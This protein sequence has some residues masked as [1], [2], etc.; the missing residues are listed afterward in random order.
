MKNSVTNFAVALQLNIA[1]GVINV[2]FIRRDKATGFRP[3]GAAN[4][5]EESRRYGVSDS[6]R[7]S[8]G[9]T[10]LTLAALLVV[11]VAYAPLGVAAAAGM[12]LLMSG[13]IVAHIRVRDPVVKSV[14]ALLMLA[15]SAAVVMIRL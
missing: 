6:F 8:M 14:P 9:V 12:V 3:D 5:A 10:K 7:R 1:L 11:G 2:W 13:A 4:I 15:M